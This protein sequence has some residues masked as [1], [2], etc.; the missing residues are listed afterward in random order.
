VAKQN[1]RAQRGIVIIL[2]IDFGQ[3]FVSFRVNTILNVRTVDSD[4]NNLPTALDCDVGMWSGWNVF[5]FYRLRCGSRSL[6]F[7]SCS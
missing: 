5:K 2:V 3:F 7:L 4:E 1:R 6:T